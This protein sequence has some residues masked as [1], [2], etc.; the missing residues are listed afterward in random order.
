MT[1]LLLP[2]LTV[3]GILWAGKEILT[4]AGKGCFDV[5]GNALL[6]RA[7]EG[8]LPPNHNLDHAL[9]Q[10][11]AKAT[12][13]LGY[14]LHDSD[15]VPLSDLIADLKL[16]TLTDRLREMLNGNIIP[17]I[18]EDDWLAALINVAKESDSFKDF[19]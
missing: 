19:I 13:V 17:R 8:T 18:P 15:R 12:C 3:P 11:L 5:F 4:R 2:L 6:S 9:R 1:E 14:A 7:R 16:G 10:S